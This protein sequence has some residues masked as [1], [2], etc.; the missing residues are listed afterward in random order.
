MPNDEGTPRAFGIGHSSFDIVV[1]QEGPEFGS[2]GRIAG[3]GRIVPLLLTLVLAGCTSRVENW[4]YVVGFDGAKLNVEVET[5]PEQQARGLM[6]REKLDPDW[7]MLFAYDKDEPIRFWMK[8]T[9]VPLSIAFIDSSGT[10]RDIQDMDPETTVAHPSPVPVR[11]GLEANRGWF[12]RHGVKPGA[13]AAF[14]PGLA[15]YLRNAFG[16][17]PGG[18]H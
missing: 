1:R 2:P 14:S 3:L 15:D 10:V 4:P 17:E 7:G 11:Y 6:Y 5:T 16:G 9:K 8:N 12:A 13:K 18:A